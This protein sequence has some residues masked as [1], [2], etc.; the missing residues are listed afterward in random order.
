MKDRFFAPVAQNFRQYAYQSNDFAALET[1]IRK[2][3]GTEPGNGILAYMLADAIFQDELSKSPGVCV[4]PRLAEAIDALGLIPAQ[5]AQYD[6]AQLLLARIHFHQE[7]HAQAFDVLEKFVARYPDNLAV[8]MML[9]TSYAAANEASKAVST[10]LAIISANPLYSAQPYLIISFMRPKSMPDGAVGYLD[11]MLDKQDLANAE[12]YKAAFARGRI[13]EAKGNMKQAF[14]FYKRGH[15]ANRAERPFDIVHERKELARLR[16]MAGET[17]VW[18]PAVAAEEDGPQAI[19]VVGMPRSGTTLTERILGAHPDVYAAGE[20]GDFAK[21]VIDVVGV[22]P[23]SEQLA[24]IDRKAAARIR[25]Q[26]LDALKAY[27]PEKRFVTNKTPANFMRIEM[28]RRVFPDA[29]IIHTHRH[30]LATCLS[31][32]TTPFSVPMRY[33]DDLGELAEYYRGY[34]ALM[35][36]SFEADDRGQMYD[37]SYEDLVSDP[38]AVARDYLA[39][40]GLDWHPGCLE[41]YRSDKAAA[42]AS[43]IQVRRPINQDSVQKWQ[44]FE[45]FIGPLAA[46]ADDAEIRQWQ[47]A[48]K[49]SRRVVAA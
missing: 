8:Q 30:P 29:P 41:F 24:G 39:H 18:D 9:A 13:E 33:S 32:Y 38:E 11:A 12:R 44:R 2:R 10:C 6:D 37:L 20:V 7:Q 5:S 4:A 34:V 40:C 27:A 49:S 22:G 36:A 45:P 28:I 25:K 3:L 21:A 1:A 43:M 46:L 17:P 26:Y 42:T 47:A 19:F 31:I 14:D 23:I 35:K 16:D 15:A 48:V